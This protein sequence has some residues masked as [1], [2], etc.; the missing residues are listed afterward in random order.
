MKKK[1]IVVADDFGFSEAYNYGAIKAYKEGIVTVLSLMSNMEAAPHAVRLWQQEAEDAC[2]VQHT[3][4]VQGYPVSRPEDIPSLVNETGRFYRSSS[5][6][7]EDGQDKKCTGN[8]VPAAED[9]YRETVAQ[10]ERHKELTGRYPV[11]LE[12]HS[13]MTAPVKE[14]FRKAAEEFRIHCMTMQEEETERMYPAHELA[15][16]NPEYMSAIMRG[17]RPEDFFEDRLGLLQSPFEINVMHFH[18]GYLDNYIFEN[19]S[20]TVPRCIDLETLCN[21]KVREWLMEHEVELV[22]FKAVYK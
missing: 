3:N 14:A 15:F 11:H 21:P 1:L 6:K 17:T 22:D 18:P 19:S 7:P 12:G 9:C 20:L 10:L 2:M 8:I 5:W 4:F 16:D 13:V